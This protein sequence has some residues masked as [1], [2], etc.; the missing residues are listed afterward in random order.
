MMRDGKRT[1][2]WGWIA[3]ATFLALPACGGSHV[4]DDDGDGTDGATDGAG[5][6]APDV[7]T[8]GP[9]ET[10]AEDG[11]A[12][13]A[14]VDVPTESPDGGPCGDTQC[15]NCIDDDG[16]TL[17]DGFDPH[18]SSA[19]DRDESSF[20]TGIPGDNRDR[21][22]QDCFFD[23][24]SGGGDDGCRFHTCCLLVT[25]PEDLASGFD[26]ATDCELSAECIEHCLPA[27]T[28]GCD[29]FGCC[30]IWVEGTSYTV[31]TNPALAPDCTLE[32]IADPASC[33]PC[34][35]TDDCDSP[36]DPEACEL[37]PGM[38]IDDLPPECSG[39]DPTCDPG[40][41][42]CVTTADCPAGYY[43]SLGCC[44]EDIILI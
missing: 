24:N 12:P 9:V 16:D 1:A 21:T 17:I 27:V 10:P 4:V 32:R 33:P 28:P 7:P 5:D 20:A 36:C 25:C 39:T 31:Y 11:I 26:E 18:C 14:P 29:C 37:C 41:T 6:G 23:G 13:D 2:I 40:V 15:S 19:A 42:P 35:P 43:C 22:W 34:V 3:T 30:T 44:I 8:D 38:T